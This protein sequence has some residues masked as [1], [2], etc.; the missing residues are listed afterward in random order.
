MLQ[1]FFHPSL[2]IEGYP[3][4][5]FPQHLQ[6]AVTQISLSVFPRVYG[7]QLF[8]K[9]KSGRRGEEG[10]GGKGRGRGGEGRGGDR[11]REGGEGMQRK[12]M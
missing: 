1:R 12:G 9:Q 11:K 8:S 6:M 5:S 10:R 4:L 2:E 3:A 7:E